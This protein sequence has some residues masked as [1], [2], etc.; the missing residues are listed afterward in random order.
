MIRRAAAVALGISL[1]GATRGQMDSQYV[2][3]RYTLAVAAVPIPKVVV[4]SYTVSQVGASNIEQR[5]TIYRSGS[6]VR[7]ETLSVDGI[8]L[9]RKIV[10]FSHHEERYTVA[11]FAPRSD[12]YELLYLGTAREDGRLDY[13]YEA[14]PLSHNA[15]AYVDRVTIDGTTFLPRVVHFRT[16]GGDAAGSGEI[17]FAPF[18]KYWMPVTASAQARVRGKPAHERIAWSD[19]RFPESLP[20]STF[21]APAPLPQATPSSN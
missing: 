16:A 17:A 21:Q 3:Q 7:D 18:G 19:Y 8:S 15:G 1:L 6:A 9:V 11:R 20:P 12:A 4:Y 14:T 5:H 2:L 13:V 10:R